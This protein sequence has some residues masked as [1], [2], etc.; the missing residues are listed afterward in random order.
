VKFNL[1]KLNPTLLF[2]SQ[3][4]SF[5]LTLAP[6][7]SR[8]A[9]DITGQ[10]TAAAQGVDGWIAS[11]IGN[12]TLRVQRGRDGLLGTAVFQSLGQLGPISAL[13]A[14]IGAEF[15]RGRGF[16]AA[17]LLAKA[18]IRSFVFSTIFRAE[19]ASLGSPE[20]EVRAE[21]TSKCPFGSRVGVLVKRTATKQLEVAGGGVVALGRSGTKLYC[22]ARSDKSAK[23]ALEFAPCT[24]SGAQATAYADFKTLGSSLGDLAP[25]IGVKVVIDPKPT[26]Q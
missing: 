6:K 8:G 4:S 13:S 12:T 1:F 15:P 21:N 5:Q 10:I 9:L 20:F 25:T 7:F 24:K 16:N 2:R 22:G 18:T 26:P 23:L 11:Q 19:T 17:Q 14:G 3:D